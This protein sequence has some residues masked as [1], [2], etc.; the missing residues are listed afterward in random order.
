MD[1]EFYDE[2]DGEQGGEFYDEQDGEFYDETDAPLDSIVTSVIQKFQ[3]RA[4]FGAKKY[5]TN[6]DRDD[7][8]IPEWI[9][10]AQEELMDA[11]LYLEKLR[12]TLEEKLELAV[13]ATYPKFP[14]LEPKN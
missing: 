9:T 7:L 6:L 12:K 1:G 11:T 3:Q 5:N 14:L 8:S 2:T 10:H 4:I 13:A